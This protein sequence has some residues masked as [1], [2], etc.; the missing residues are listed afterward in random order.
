MM[1]CYFPILYHFL[2]FDSSVW[3]F[4]DCCVLDEVSVLPETVLTVTSFAV[5]QPS[6]WIISLLRTRRKA[7][8]TKIAL[9]V[10]VITFFIIW[11]MNVNFVTKRSCHGVV[12]GYLVGQANAL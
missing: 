8:R 5:K 2:D 6:A 11:N 1:L 3:P 12:K 9:H 4:G 10:A 7:V